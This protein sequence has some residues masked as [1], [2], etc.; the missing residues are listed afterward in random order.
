MKRVLIVIIAGVALAPAGKAGISFAGIPGNFTL[1]SLVSAKSQQ[2]GPKVVFNA[3]A[4]RKSDARLVVGGG[5]PG[6]RKAAFAAGRDHR[7]RLQLLT[8]R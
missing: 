2:T 7:S 8:S 1:D 3:K 6:A 5:D 4:V